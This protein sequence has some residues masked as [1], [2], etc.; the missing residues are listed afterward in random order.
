M[1][2]ARHASPDAFT[3][4][5]ASIGHSQGRGT[6]W[7][8]SENEKIAGTESSENIGDVAIAPSPRIY[9][10]SVTSPI[11][12]KSS[13]FPPLIADADRAANPP[14]TKI[15][16]MSGTAGERAKLVDVLQLC[17]HGQERWMPTSHSA[18]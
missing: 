1:I 8:P 4:R 2:G 15:D 5:W 10:L 9:G 12:T 7:G 16:L 17:L 14:S 6:V 3:R 18:A 11:T 13:S